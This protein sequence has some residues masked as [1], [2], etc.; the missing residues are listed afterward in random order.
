[1]L[2]PLPIKAPASIALLSG[3]AVPLIAFSF[4]MPA[5]NGAAPNPPEK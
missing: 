3:C 4:W 5:A 1:M 2:A